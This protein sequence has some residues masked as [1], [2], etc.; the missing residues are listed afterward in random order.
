MDG[1]HLPAQ[2]GE[3]LHGGRK[4]LDVHRSEQGMFHVKLVRQEDITSLAH[5]GLQFLGPPAILI[6]DEFAHAYG[7]DAQ[8]LVTQAAYVPQHF[9]HPRTE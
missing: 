3:L 8:I 7:Q 4:H 6:G 2:V 1:D 9:H 5:V